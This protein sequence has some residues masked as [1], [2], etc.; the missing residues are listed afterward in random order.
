MHC[1]SVSRKVLCFAIGL[2]FVFC[3]VSNPL[4]VFASEKISLDFDGVSLKEFVQYISEHTGQNIVAPS[5]IQGTV[6][7]YSPVGLNKKDVLDTFISIMGA[8]GYAIQKNASSW[9]ITPFNDTYKQNTLS[10][11]GVSQSIETRIIPLKNSIAKELERVLPALLV[12]DFAITSYSGSNTLAITAPSSR[13]QTAIAFIDAIEKNHIDAKLYTF[14]L[15]H[16]NAKLVA[17]AVSGILKS[18]DEE[19]KKKGGVS[20][21][22]IV[23]DERTDAVLVYGNKETY[24]IVKE[25]LATV[26]IPTPK[27]KGDVHHIQLS[28]GKAEDIAEVINTLI[29]RQVA[30]TSN[31]E[32]EEFTLSRDIKVVPD[33]ATNS[34]VVTAR[35]DEFESLSKIIAKLD[36]QRQQVFI[37]ALI[38][39]VASSDSAS[40]GIDWAVAGDIATDISLFGGVSL[41]GSGINLGSNKTASL[42]S[43]ASIGGILSDAF[44]VGGTSYNIQSLLNLSKGNSNV[45]ILATPQ[46]LTL[47]NAE[48]NFEVVDNIPFSRE[49]TESNNA[50]FTTQTIDYK[51]VGVKLK[52]TPRI[53]TDDTLKLEVEQEISRVTQGILTFSNGNQIVAP[54]TR[55]RLVQSTILLKD[56]QTAVIGGLL[57]NNQS[58]NESGVPG[59]SKIPVAGWLFKSRSKENVQT[60]LFVFI[61]PK[62]IKNFEAGAKLTADKRIL[63][64]QASFGENGLVD[65]IVSPP[66]LLSPVIV[67]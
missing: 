46:L 31:E 60:N 49:S 55:K 12:K 44:T 13:I 5:N 57:D 43:G 66:Q 62:I 4:K 37:E 65:S 41:N 24:A 58:L 42:P 28:N 20:V 19:L 52:I 14:K 25:V 51:D 53:S 56:G 33:L 23:P 39:E 38:L 64:N 63:L 27:G 59:L 2:M 67:F 21:S 29:E 30:G 22:M 3:L 54:T 40:F 48:A 18:K 11:D 45:N 9:I 50:E 17:N 8:N 34:L 10:S 16:A 1:L 26:D 15:E 36:V 35:A 32:E 61:T 7:I 47:D 6:T